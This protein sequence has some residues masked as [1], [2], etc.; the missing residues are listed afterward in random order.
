MISFHQ[1]VL[2]EKGTATVRRCEYCDSPVPADA[3]VCPVCRQ[4]ISEETLERVLPLLKRPHAPEVRAMSTMERL[5]GVIRRPGPTYRDI[6]QRPD[7][8]GPLM[9]VMMNALVLVGFFL[10]ISSKFTVPVVVNGTPIDISVLDSNL[11]GPYYGTAL[12]S[13]VPNIM[14][15]MVYLF[16]GSLF[17][18]IAFKV[19]GGTG[20][21]FKTL[22]IVGYS[23]MPVFLFRLIG[24]L[25]V[26]LV[27]PSYA[28]QNVSSWPSVIGSIYG[29]DVWLILDY[30]TTAAFV[31][32]GF[33]L[34]LG[35]REAHDTST[36]WAFIVSVACM[37]VLGWT[38]WQ[39][40]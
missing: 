19:T 1:D 28:V 27:M 11:A 2:V 29:S 33:L 17:A 38:F 5:W 13:I 23:M 10:I 9:I 26:S 15:G 37:I 7:G 8:A 31:W 16:L 39:A 30:M 18:H 22:S 21:L 36:I 6:G 40:H 35:I 3:T 20:R 12:A 32:V 4:V 25:V 24:L 34:T 14:I